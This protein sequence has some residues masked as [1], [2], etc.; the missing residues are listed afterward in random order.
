M[1]TEL[2]TV[3]L[4][5]S[6]AV[7]IAAWYV[8]GLELRL[9]RIQKIALDA[10]DYANQS[11]EFVTKGNAE[12]VSLKQV[13]DLQCIVMDLKDSYEQVLHVQRKLCLKIGARDRRAAQKNGETDLSS[14]DKTQL[15]IQAKSLGILK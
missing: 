4:F 15:R 8:V 3:L 7:V 1:S 6:L 5:S 13:T 12:S 11:N 2:S 10:V 14:D 9:R